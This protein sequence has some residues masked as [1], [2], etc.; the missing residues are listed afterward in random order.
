M[1]A[2][3]FDL[4]GVLIE[5][6]PRRLYRNH[7]A[8]EARMER[9]LAEVCTPVW[10]H[11]IDL[12]LPLGQAVAE[13]QAACPEHADL[14]ALYDREWPSMLGEAIAGTVDLLGELKGRGVKVCA[15]SNWSAETFPVA[16]ARFPFLGWFDRI[17]ISGDVGL[18]KPDPAIFA[19]A[20][21]ECGLEAQ[22]TVFVDDVPANVAVARGLGL[23]ALLFE[24]PD[25][26]RLAL[27]ARGLVS[28]GIQ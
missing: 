18:A 24:G 8:D 21:A 2:V 26:L 20:L 11:A 14:I 16:V 13:R 19:L 25:P 4:G 28:P 5:W 9:F 1:K 6:D 15:L 27:A 22:E 3:L 17:I 7:F 12:G 23:D 10:N